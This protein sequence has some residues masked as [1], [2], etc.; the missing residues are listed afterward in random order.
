MDNTERRRR[1]LVDKSFQYSL[2][3]LLGAVWLC[4]MVVLGGLIYYLYAVFVFRVDPVAGQ[5]DMQPLVVQPP[6]HFF[7]LVTVGALLGLALVISVGLH[8][9]HQIAGPLVQLKTRLRQVAQGD[10]NFDMRFRHGDYLADLPYCFNEMMQSLKERSRSEIETLK[11]IEAALDE[12]SPGRERLYE[13]LEE[14]E[15][16]L[17]GSTPAAPSDESA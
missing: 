1:L 5:P 14:K 10:M 7:V 15:A 16:L 17:T 3:R 8:M 13:F 4:N 6:L 12:P 2:I 9:S 11:A